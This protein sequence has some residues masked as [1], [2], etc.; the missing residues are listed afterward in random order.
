[1]DGFWVMGGAGGTARVLVSLKATIQALTPSPGLVAYSTDTKEVW[2]ADGTAWQKIPFALVPDPL[3]PDMGWTQDS[4]R[5]GLAPNYVDSKLLTRA[6]IGTTSRELNGGV[7]YDN[8]AVGFFGRVAGVWQKFVTGFK[9][10][11]TA[12]RLQWQPATSPEWYDAARLNSTSVGLNGLPL[13]QDG[14]A[15]MGI[16]PLPL[17]IDGGNVDMSAPNPAT[18]RFHGVVFRIL[19]RRMTNAERL[20]LGI[21]ATMQGEHVFETDTNAEYISD[22]AGGWVG[23]L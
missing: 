23:P 16:L 17:I 22:G 2:V 10:L 12:L 15:S 7:R 19:P 21:D 1:M 18:L 8:V 20:A 6:V 13:V 11:E 3:P 4:S 14:Q 5:I 9:F